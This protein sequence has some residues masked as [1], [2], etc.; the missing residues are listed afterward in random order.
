MQEAISLTAKVA[1]R[2]CEAK[3]NKMAMLSTRLPDAHSWHISR[4]S[5]SD[6]NSRNHSRADIPISHLNS[7]LL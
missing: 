2:L 4:L 5:L 3:G 7:L 6:A 1:K